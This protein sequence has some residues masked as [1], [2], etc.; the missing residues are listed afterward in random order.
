MKS[1]EMG[2]DFLPW[3]NWR[4]VGRYRFSRPK[5]WLSTISH[6]DSSYQDPTLQNSASGSPSNST[7]NPEDTSLVSVNPAAWFWQLK[8]YAPVVKQKHSQLITSLINLNHTFLYQCH[9]CL[10][11]L[12]ANI[13]HYHIY[14][15]MALWRLQTGDWRALLHPSPKSRWGVRY[16][17]LIPTGLTR[18]WWTFVRG[19]IL[20]LIHPAG[21]WISLIVTS[22]LWEPKQDLNYYHTSVRSVWTY[23]WVSHW[24]GTLPGQLR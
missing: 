15:N 3:H 18:V 21:T 14:S 2:G 17:S 9:L 11:L 19:I 1:Q 4:S 22:I 6:W 10:L 7:I 16:T 23:Y 13:G 12:T 5:S 24:A 20:I 8:R